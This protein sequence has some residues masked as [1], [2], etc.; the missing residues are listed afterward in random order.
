MGHVASLIAQLHPSS[1]LHKQH[2]I[3][4]LAELTQEVQELC[5]WAPDRVALQWRWDLD[6]AVDSIIIKGQSAA[7]KPKP[8]LDTSDL[9]SAYLS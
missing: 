4:C 5:L 7:A 3:R 6:V 9:D 1:N 2:S 8:T